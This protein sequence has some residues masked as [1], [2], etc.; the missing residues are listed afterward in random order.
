MPSPF[1]LRRLLPSGRLEGRRGSRKSRK[2]R[3]LPRR[4]L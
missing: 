1:G 4:D 2:R 3:G